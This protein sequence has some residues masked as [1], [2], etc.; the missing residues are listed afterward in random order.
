MTI[1]KVGGLGVPVAAAL[2]LAIPLL[3]SNKEKEAPSWVTEVAT[4]ATPAYSGKVPAAVLLDEQ[5]VTVD[6]SGMV[7]TVTR[8]AVKILTHDGKREAEVTE[9]YEKGG[10]QVKELHAWLVAPGGFVKTYEKN[11]VQDLGAY[12]DELYNDYRLKHIQADNPEIGAVFIYESEVAEKAMT[13]QDRFLFQVQLPEVESRY[14]ITVPVGWRASGTILNHAPVTPAVDGNTYTWTLKDLPYRESEE[15]APQLYG[16]APLL[17]VDYQPPAGV[18]DPPAF[19]AWPDVSRWYARIVATQGEISPEMAAKVQQLTAGAKTEYDKIHALGEYVQKIR[20]VE[21]AMDLA[22][23]GGFRPHAAPQV[24]AKGYG[25]CKDKANLLSAMLKSAGIASYPVVI[26]SGDRTHV[27]KDWASPEQFNHMI[28]AV[29]VPDTVKVDTVMD[30]PVGRIL[31]FDPTDN[32]TPMGDLPFYEQGSYALLCAGARGDILQMPVI[33]PD[34]NVISQTIEA[35]LDANGTLTASLGMQAE[36]QQARRER[37][38]H[39]VS[40]DQYKAAMERYLAYYSHSASVS[41]VEAQDSFDRN[42]FTSRVEFQSHGYGQVMQ[43][44]LLVFNPSVTEPAASH[45]TVARERQLPVVLNARVYR[46]QVTVTLPDGFTVDEM[47]SPYQAQT[48]FAKFTIAFRQEQGKLIVEEELRTE[49]VTIPASDYVNVKQ[50]FDNV[51][52]ANN[53]SAVLVKK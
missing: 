17:A 2:M 9:G 19:H 39:D 46:K 32:L 3:A 37:M 45:F 28:L 11:D 4:R 30:S 24:F 52:G 12:G 33:S 6:P 14:S 27:K 16:N 38:L 23:N 20:Y 13:A 15:A 21:I 31:L 10:R 51:Y 48:P 49:A 36:G 8:H 22:H 18:A 35:S 25:D 40:S 29:N 53:Q 42:S 43:G 44:R 26:Y 50:F 7:D 41:K 1:F 5:K 34:H 47:P